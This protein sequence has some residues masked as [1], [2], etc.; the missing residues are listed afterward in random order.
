MSFD[1]FKGTNINKENHKRSAVTNI[2]KRLIPYIT[3][4]TKKPVRLEN[5]TVNVYNLR[6]HYMSV[7]NETSVRSFCHDSNRSY[8]LCSFYD[9]VKSKVFTIESHNIFIYD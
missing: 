3:E 5:K 7:S 4:N 9:V 6:A 2:I 8:K 1:L